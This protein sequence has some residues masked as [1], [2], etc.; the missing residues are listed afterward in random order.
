MGSIPA[1][2]PLRSAVVRRLLAFVVAVAMVAGALVIRARR[3]DGNSGGTQARK[4]RPVIACAVELTDACRALSADVAVDVVYEPAA[5]TL[6]HL[7]AKGL[8]PVD[9]WVVPQPWPAI[10]D[11][12]RRRAAEDAVLDAGPALARS[13]LALVVNRERAAKLPCPG[14]IQWRCLGDAA[15][16]RTWAAVGGSPSWGQI[17]IAHGDPRNSAIG[18][19][20]VGQAT[21]GYL[22][23][24]TF[25]SNDLQDDDGY[26][27][28]LAGLEAAVPPGTFSSVSPLSDMLTRFPAGYDVVATTAAE[29]R[30]IVDANRARVDLIYPSP[31]ASA[32]VVLAAVKGGRAVTQLREPLRAALREARWD[33]PGSG[34]NRLPS[35]GVLEY[36]LAEVLR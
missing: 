33:A 36:L 32:D 29:A 7:T 28:W 5:V 1:I 19:L 21:A 35:A 26:S 15:A 25:S 9:G 30:A 4:G 16:K 34:G 3:D 13:P 24:E 20:V 23:R 17:K 31:M 27:P 11:D 12:V 2:L 10:A 6:D 8:P 14:G 18:L 22:G